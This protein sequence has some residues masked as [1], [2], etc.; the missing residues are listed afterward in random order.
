[1]LQEQANDAGR[2]DKRGFGNALHCDND[3]E[4]DCADQDRWHVNNGT[5][6]KHDDRSG[7]RTGSGR[8]DPVDE[9]LNACA[10]G[11]TAKMWRDTRVLDCPTLPSRMWFVYQVLN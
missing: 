4:R 2:R 8:R 11:K 5:S 9:C 3:A 6:P 10:L 7:D 1:M